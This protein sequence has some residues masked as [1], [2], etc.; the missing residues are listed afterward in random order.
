MAQQ[1]FS[2]E[3]ILLAGFNAFSLQFVKRANVNEPGLRSE[4]YKY[5]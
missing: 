2:R 3:I 4:H 5:N 1:F